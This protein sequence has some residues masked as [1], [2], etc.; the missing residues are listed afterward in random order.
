DKTGRVAVDFQFLSADR[1]SEGLAA[2]E[3]LPQHKR[4]YI[5]AKGTMVI[6]PKFDFA[7]AFSEGLA[8]VLYGGRWIRRVHEHTGRAV[9]KGRWGF[10][11]R[12]GRTVIRLSKAVDYAGGFKAGVASVRLKDGRV[13]Y[14]DRKGR[15]VW[16]PSK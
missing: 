4:G 10:V 5:D 13:G 16:R 3:V 9:V 7:F 12:K 14:I 15:Y 8:P 6:Q 11:D 2:I 1:F